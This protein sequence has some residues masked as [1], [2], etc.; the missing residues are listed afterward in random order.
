MCNDNNT[1]MKLTEQQ[2]AAIKLSHDTHTTIIFRFILCEAIIIPQKGQ[3]ALHI[4]AD[5]GHCLA[6]KK[7]MALNADV[8]AIDTSVGFSY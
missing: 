5:Q 1:E 3:T 4:A 8:T 6:I 2:L 7:L